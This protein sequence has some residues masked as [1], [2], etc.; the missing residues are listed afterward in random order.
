MTWK[1][2]A[3]TVLLIAIVLTAWI[4]LS[5]C[6]F[7]SGRGGGYHGDYDHHDEHHG[8]DHGDRR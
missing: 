5:G 1:K 8:D 6:F 4:V 3:L 2:I 7:S